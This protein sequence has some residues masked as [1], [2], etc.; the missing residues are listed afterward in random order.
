MAL[1][2][3][4]RN[5]S[6]ILIVMIALGLGG[7]IIMDMTSGQQSIFGSGQTIMGSIDGEKVD[8]NNFY[9]MEQVLYGS[10]PGDVYSRRNSLWNY[11]VEEKLVQQEAEEI[12]LGVSKTELL[13]LQFGQ[14]P[15]P[16][17][18][19]RFTDPNAPGQVN[20]EQLN[21]IKNLIE[22]GGIQDAINNGQ[23]N[24]TFVPYW[25]HQEKEIIKE[26][27]QGKLTNL[28]TKA[29]YTPT[30]MAEMG[31]A[32]QN[33]RVDF[34]YVKVPFDE[35]DNSEVTLEDSDYSAFIK[36][37][38]NQYEQDEE[39]RQIEYISFNVG[40]TAADS[41]NL[42]QEI[43]DLVPQFKT[44]EN[45]SIFVETYYGS[46]DAAYVKKN[47]LSPV[48]ADTV[49]SMPV[50]EVYG[51]YFDA[52]AYKAVKL[53]D[54]KVIPDSVRSR[55]ILQPAQDPVSLQ[56][57]IN[58]IDSLKTLIENGTHT[59]DSL[60]T[61]FGTDG[62]ASK[63]GDL[64]Y[65]AMGGMVKPFNDLIFFEA[66]EGKLYT[67]IT[68]FGVHLVEVTGRKYINN[69]EGVKVAYL[70]QT[71]VPSEETQ[72][73]IYEDVLEFVGQN[74]SY[75]QLVESVNANPNLSLESAPSFQK[76]DFQVGTLGSNNTS[77]SLVR[78]A[79]GA[80]K[81]DVS[82]EIYTYQDPIENYNN[83]YVIATLTG[84]QKAGIPSVES[85]RDQIEQLIIN[86]KKGELIVDRIKDMDMSTIASTYSTSIDTARNVNFV[87]TFVQD[88]GSEPKVMASAFNLNEN[89]ISAPIVGQ[90]GVF[91]VKMVRRPIL[92]TAS[93]I[94]QLRQNISSQSRSQVAAQLIPA[95][96][97]NADI[98]DNRFKFY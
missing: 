97:K 14:N 5:N 29:M 53:I 80:S 68:Q 16:L 17:I 62:T 33:L 54:R 70:S 92:A 63:G 94:P 86:E 61:A 83:K 9:R 71:I 20:R 40:P 58:R 23:L 44:A 56:A 81:G 95:V 34:A 46:I 47:T 64:G 67:V 2:G 69:E 65:A 21:Y 37:N 82:P 6:W 96:R 22:T 98:S 35:L 8:W 43:A 85:I 77:R 7:F 78:W 30:W 72:N 90:T 73:S 89:E 75:N 48:I 4:I 66:E 31:H 55:H 25:A 32:D 36:E 28:V 93:N 15:S 42:Q 52:G 57:S 18:R 12:G 60:A 39:T 3:Q 19:Q 79:F 11:F 91:V 24:P 49:F 13:D 74:R 27:L 50:G 87:Q 45:D 84:I 88:L 1:I 41:A 51:P 76:N 38:K 59:F 10:S 26:R